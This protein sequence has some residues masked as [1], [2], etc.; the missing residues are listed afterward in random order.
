MQLSRIIMSK[1]FTYYHNPACSK[2]CAGLELLKQRLTDFDEQ[3]DIIEYLN[4]PPS[5]DSLRKIANSLA[6]N[7]DYSSLIRSEVENNQDLEQIILSIT[8]QPNLLQRP[9]LINNTTG[10]AAIGRPTS[11]FEK[12]I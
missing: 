1:A 5:A 9:I 6:L 11:N 3:V 8:E 2:S 12:L 4:S 10:K 7:P